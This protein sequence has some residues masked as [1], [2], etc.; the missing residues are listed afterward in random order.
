MYGETVPTMKVTHVALLPTETAQNANRPA[1]TPELLAATGARYSRSGEGLKA[2]LGRID[3]DNL[4]KS[5]DGIFRMIDYGHQSIADMAPVALFVDGISL[6]LA[7]YLWTLCPT[8][9]GQETSTRYVELGPEGLVSAEA[10]GIPEE[11]RGAWGKSM[12]EAFGAYQTALAF[13]TNAVKENPALLRI[14]SRLQNDISDKAQKA[15][16]RMARNFAF[17][18]ARYF[19][20]AASQ[21]NVVLVQSARAW[22]QVLQVLLSHPLLEARALGDLARAELGF[23]APRLLRHARALPTMQAGLADEFAAVRDIAAGERLDADGS[24]A[25]GFD[26][27]A[28][29]FLEVYPPSGLRDRAADRAF[30]RDLSHHENRYAYQGQTLQRTAVRF[31]W[32]AAAWAEIRDLNRHRTGTKYCPLVPVGFYHATDELPAPDAAYVDLGEV[33]QKANETGREKLQKGDPTYVYDLLL[34]TQFYFE[35]TTT[36]D[37]FLYEAELRTGMGA[38]PR[39]AR[40]LRDALHLWYEKFPQTRGLI[41]EGSAEP[42]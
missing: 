29:A 24:R 34:G 13:W 31:G 23:A 14:P 25:N 21:T 12:R 16:R 20:P 30:V 40:H 33:G 15:V 35:H 17:D 11:N 7:Y 4:D 10:V 6:W 32:E 36:A 27:E 28:S 18:R 38:H 3:P 2:I 8:A 1:L 41:L 9:G 39:Y 26:R 42:E 5:V 37:K 19:L 22:V